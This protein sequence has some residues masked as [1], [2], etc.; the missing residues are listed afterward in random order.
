MNIKKLHKNK[1]S[2]KSFR[3][4]VFII[5]IINVLCSNT[6]LAFR[7][8]RFID[9]KSLWSAVGEVGSGSGTLITLDRVLTAAHCVCLALQNGQMHCYRQASFRIT[10]ANGGFV[11][12]QG[13][14]DVYPGYRRITKNEYQGFDLA[15]IMLDEN[16]KQIVRNAYQK[17]LIYYLPIEFTNIPAIGTSFNLVGYGPTDSQCQGSGGRKNS[18]QLGVSWVSSSEMKFIYTYVYGCKG[19]SGGPA[20]NLMNRV[21]GV[22]TGANPD[23]N[24]T[25]CTLIP[26]FSGWIMGPH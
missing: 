23:T 7:N 9:D 12:L 11:K 10:L 18:I 1:F 21:A 4:I 19:D 2:E 14:V 6:V 5:L 8:G 24:L 20:L 15:V 3:L 16:S 26:P 22:V 25:A 13:R 17:G